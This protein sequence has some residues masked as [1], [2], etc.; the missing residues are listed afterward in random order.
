LPSFR[1]KQ[2]ERSLKG[3]QFFGMPKK[4]PFLKLLFWDKKGFGIE[5]TCAKSEFFYSFEGRSIYID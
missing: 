4:V 2:R 5:K 1:P 3:S